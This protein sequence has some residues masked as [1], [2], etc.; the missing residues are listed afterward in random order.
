MLFFGLLSSFLLL[1]V[2]TQRFSRF[3]PRSSSGVSC[4]YGHRNDS[5]WWIIFKVWLLIKKGFISEKVYRC[6]FSVG[7]RHKRVFWGWRKGGRKQYFFY[8]AL[9]SHSHRQQS[10]FSPI[11]PY[12]KFLHPPTTPQPPKYLIRS[13][14]TLLKTRRNVTAYVQRVKGWWGIGEK[15]PRVNKT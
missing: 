10:F 6:Y 14:K 13:M 9:A 8:V 1:L 12:N 7:T 2:V 4:L 11:I 15:S 5:T 3:V